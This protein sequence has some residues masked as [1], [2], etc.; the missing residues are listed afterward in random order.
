MLAT[1]WQAREE[2]SKQQQMNSTE[3][4]NQFRR[5]SFRV[6]EVQLTL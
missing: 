4:G 2:Q 5:A 6:P 3:I 1:V